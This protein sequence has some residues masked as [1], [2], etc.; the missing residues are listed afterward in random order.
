MERVIKYG[1]I[2][3]FLSLI[4]VLFLLDLYPRENNSTQKLPEAGI[5]NFAQKINTRRMFA[6]GGFYP[7]KAKDLDSTISNL[8][9]QAQRRISPE[10]LRMLIV[11]HAGL[12]YSGRTAANAFKQLEGKKYTRVI[13]I[14]AS[15]NYKFG[16]AA[17]DDSEFW[18][19][20]YGNV[21]IDKDLENKLLSSRE[22]II[23][24][25]EVHIKEHSLELEVIFLKKVLSDFKI[26]PILVSQPSEELVS[27]LAYKISRNMDDNTL[28]VVSTDLSHYPNYETANR[29][30]RETIE[31]ILTGKKLELERAFKANSGYV[32][33]T[34]CGYE[35]LRI[36]L[37]AGELLGLGEATLL[38]YENSG[39]VT[40][41][42]EKVVGYAVIGF[43]SG[44]IEL[45]TL[46]LSLEAK[47][48]ALEIA[49]TVLDNFVRFQKSPDKITPK[50]Q[51][52]YEPLGA[53]VTLK[54]NG[55]LR[56]CIGEFEPSK[57]LYQVIQEKTIDAASRDRRFNPV[58]QSELES[59]D[60]EI[61]VME[62]KKLITDWRSIKLGTDGVV[63]SQGNKAGTF[64]PIVGRENKWSL[65][66]FLSELCRQ[67]AGLPA[68]CYNNPAT[69]IYKFSAQEFGEED[70]K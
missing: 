37:K 53:F 48:E 69:S 28:L 1:L 19:T 23:K 9:S 70:L 35:A 51:E 5:Q 41:N 58:T 20:P 17:L 61:S 64:L 49:K 22:K 54:N 44:T 16:H 15:H 7:A 21:E 3:F 14:G 43:Y 63:V 59:I 13:V 46:I 32:Q 4:P 52:L 55:K 38:R 57:P 47:K 11:P 25:R 24:D 10:R 68:D 12:S 50:N 26:V 36:A 39:D 60:L 40:D 45:K 8:L 42:K 27:A 65:E 56:G 66:E 30:D 29:V 18:E 6:A 2:V 62:P 33:T 34:A 67:K 31:A